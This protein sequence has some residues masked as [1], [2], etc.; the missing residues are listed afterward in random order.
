MGDL[1][2][3]RHGETAWTITGQHASYTDLPLTPEGERQARGLGVVLSGLH[4]GR[5]LSSPRIR[6]RQTARLAGL[7]AP[8]LRDDLREWDYGCYEGLRT[9]NIFRRRPGW[10]LW[11]DGAPAEGP[12]RPGES[13]IQ[14]GERADR[15]LRD[16]RA[17]LVADHGDVVVVGHGHF[18]RVLAV[19][20]LGLPTA[21][22]AVFH[23]A[24]AAVGRL[25]THRG[26]PVVL[27]WNDRSSG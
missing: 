13:P 27:G 8:E 1:V 25:G 20:H 10:S 26:R 5:V 3:V 15:L 18:L 21:C 11:R 22:G 2:L 14:V 24:P 16:L 23:L 9:T 7:P 12:G 6:A 19:R 4:F 17:D